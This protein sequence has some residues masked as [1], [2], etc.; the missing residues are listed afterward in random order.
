MDVVDCSL[1]RRQRLTQ[2]SP[3]P[4]ANPT[5]NP[6]EGSRLGVRQAGKQAGAVARLRS[7]FGWRSSESTPGGRMASF[8]QSDIR[9]E[10]RSLPILH[11]GPVSRLRLSVQVRRSRPTA[12]LWVSSRAKRFWPPYIGTPPT[13]IAL[14]GDPYSR[15]P[16]QE[17]G[18][19]LCLSRMKIMTYK[20]S[21]DQ[22]NQ[23]DDLRL[24]LIHI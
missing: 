21:C 10:I 12:L 11:S 22:S 5:P 2:P 24:S 14:M 4:N 3:S 19:K 9:H 13:H 15:A 8:D 20:Y 18:V 1:A 16:D 7:L 6:L 23:S 17:I